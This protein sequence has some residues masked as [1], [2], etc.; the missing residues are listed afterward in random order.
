MKKGMWGILL[1]VLAGALF[2]FLQ[3]KKERPLPNLSNK[4]QEEALRATL[5]YLQKEVPEIA[6]MEIQAN[7]V[8]LGW[9]SVPANFDSINRDAAVQANRALN[10]DVHVWSVSET[11]KGWRPGNKSFICE[12]VARFGKVKESSCE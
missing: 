2:M 9:K 7:N 10:F 1:V 12:T 4:S 5:S 11:Q 6:W 8:Y 3:P